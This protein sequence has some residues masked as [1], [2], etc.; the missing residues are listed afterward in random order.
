[1]SRTA[2]L[3]VLAFLSACSG[4]DLASSGSKGKSP[5]SKQVSSA[6]SGTGSDKASNGPS[7]TGSEA[8]LSSTVYYAPINAA[9]SLPATQ[10]PTLATCKPKGAPAVSCDPI[11]KNVHAT[12]P[13][14]IGF[15]GTDA[16]GGPVTF[17]VVFYDPE[18]P[19]TDP[20]YIGQREAEAKTA[21]SITTDS[22]EVTPSKALSDANT[23]LRSFSSWTQSTPEGSHVAGGIACPAGLAPIGSVADCSGSSGVTCFGNLVFCAAINKI[24]D[25]AAQLVTVDITMTPEGTHQPGG[26][27]CAAGYAQFGG[28][29]D[30]G[31]SSCYG[32]QIFCVKQVPLN[33]LTGGDQIVT[34]FAFG[35]E[36]AHVVGGV[37]CASGYASIG[38]T[39]D[40]GN[41][42]NQ[43]GNCNGNQMFCLQKTALKDAG[44]AATYTTWSQN[45]PAA[46]HKIGGLPC[47]VGGVPVGS[48]ADCSGSNGVT[49]SGNLPLCAIPASPTTLPTDPLTTDIWITPEGTHNQSTDGCPPGYSP[50]G[51]VPDCHLSSCLGN[52]FL[53][54]RTV[55]RGAL[56]AGEP[57]VKSVVLT[58]EG[59]RVAGGPACPAGFTAVGSVADCGGAHAQGQDCFGNQLV[60]VAKGAP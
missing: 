36:S 40:C 28:I 60:C 27:A 21:V 15:E 6:A 45:T 4:A 58:A 43:G 53:C 10:I 42:S 33:T 41:A 3:L 54:S 37:A 13:G 9:T 38:S 29:P 48:F 55:Q 31:T 50:I 57:V 47:P 19:P 44:K 20:A 14:T 30:C 51:G 18:T 23:G 46:T 11:T 16:S 8:A 56:A 7:G 24:S 32:N 12:K 49:C 35:A 34:D 5:T 1:M 17:T 22:S 39:A 25:S 59:A 52:Q 2:S 26:I